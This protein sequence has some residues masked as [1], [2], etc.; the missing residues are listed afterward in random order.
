MSSHAG[1]APQGP[2]RSQDR[3]GSSAEGSS[4]DPPCD[5]VF[6]QFCK[7]TRTCVCIF[8]TIGLTWLKDRPDRA[9]A[10]A[11]AIGGAL[12]ERTPA[13]CKG[14]LKGGE[15]GLLQHAEN[16][17]RTAPTLGQGESSESEDDDE[18]VQQKVHELF[19]AFLDRR[20]SPGAKHAQ[21]ERTLAGQSKEHRAKIQKITAAA[22]ARVASAEQAT[23]EMAQRH[24]EEKG[25]WERERRAHEQAMADLRERGDATIRQL[26]EEFGKEVGVLG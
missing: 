25:E 11:K 10:I 1:E 19:H 12:P 20:I 21:K 9:E 6:A 3:Q 7:E 15:T 17:K 13:G 14:S 24:Q 5:R 4:A 16:K 2:P 18:A 8:S 22:D 23:R 26:E